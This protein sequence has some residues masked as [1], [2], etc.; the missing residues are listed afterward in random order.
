MLVYGEGRWVVRSRMLMPVKA[1]ADKNL[2]RQ[3][4]E[5]TLLE[6]LLPHWQT[7]TVTMLLV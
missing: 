2:F 1:K 7:G 6:M 3:V 4:G 5:V